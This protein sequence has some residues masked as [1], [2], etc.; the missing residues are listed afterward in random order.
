MGH[1]CICYPRL[2]ALLREHMRRREVRRKGRRAASRLA[3][4]VHIS[5]A[6]RKGGRA[7][8]SSTLVES[9][10][11]S[12]TGHMSRRHEPVRDTRGRQRMRLTTALALG[13]TLD[14]LL[15]TFQPSEYG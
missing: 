10:L 3:G 6:A 14:A 13:P 11:A 1:F 15:I 9:V 5:L 7:V 2:S 12:L 4:L 8:R